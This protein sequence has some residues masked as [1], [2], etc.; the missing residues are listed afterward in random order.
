MFD[1]NFKGKTL[2]ELGGGYGHNGNEFSKMGAIV[3][4]TDA[5]EEH[6]NNGKIIYPHMSFMLLDSDKLQIEKKYDIILHWGLLYH[7]SEIENHLNI[8]CKNCD[9]L[10]LETEVCDSDNEFFYLTTNENGYDQAFNSIGIRPSQQYVEKILRNN[11]FEYKMII[12]PIINSGFHN[13][14]WTIANTNA[15]RHGLRRFWICKKIT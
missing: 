13:Y 11:G 8:V 10:L 4:S 2:L 3:T 12:D 14:D 7:L 1:Y 6:I 9:I 5:R 15:W